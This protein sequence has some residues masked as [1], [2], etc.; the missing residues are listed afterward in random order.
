MTLQLPTANFH[1]SLLYP[2]HPDPRPKLL[3][4]NGDE[5]IHR[6][7][8]WARGQDFEVWL[9]GDPQRALEV[10][11]TEHPGVV[12]LDLDLLAHPADV[13]GGLRA[14]SG[15]LQHARG[16][17]VIIIMAHLEQEY[18]REAIGHGA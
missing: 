15:I 10:L 3:M 9:A 2:V 16:A 14:L 5:A 13:D 1:S 8:Q 12:T 18:A 7:L 11:R 4:L 17:K 6:Q